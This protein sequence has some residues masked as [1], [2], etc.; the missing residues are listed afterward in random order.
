MLVAF[1]NTAPSRR[2]PQALAVRNLALESRIA[3]S[4]AASKAIFDRNEELLARIGELEATLAV[5]SVALTAARGAFLLYRKMLTGKRSGRWQ[6][7]R[8][9]CDVKLL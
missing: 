4:E 3:A 2:T 8:F 1:A 5:Q 9:S 7:G 6:R